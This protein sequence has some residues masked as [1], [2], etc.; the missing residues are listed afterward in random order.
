VAGLRQGEFVL[1]EKDAGEKSGVQRRRRVLT[2]RLTKP[3]SS[4][5]ADDE[6]IRVALHQL[7]LIRRF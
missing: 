6:S 1:Y 4:H 3:P 5:F 2:R 7:V